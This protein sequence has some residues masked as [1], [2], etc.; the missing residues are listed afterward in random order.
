MFAPEGYLFT[1]WCMQR[2][3]GDCWHIS[4]EGYSATDRRNSKAGNR[5]GLKHV[6]CHSLQAAVGCTWTA[7]VRSSFQAER[8][9][10]LPQ[11]AAHVAVLAARLIPCKIQLGCRSQVPE[12]TLGQSNRQ[13]VQGDMML[14]DNPVGALPL[15]ALR[16]RW[17]KTSDVSPKPWRCEPL[18]MTMRRRCP[19]TTFL[20]IC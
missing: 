9:Q 20:S 4:E 11:R 1:A 6:I 5:P 8:Y 10:V 15:Y 19:A 13:A 17:C 14:L 16:P 12:H 7:Q 2:Y 18:A 3:H